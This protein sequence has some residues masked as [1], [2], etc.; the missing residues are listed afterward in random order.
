VVVES[1]VGVRHIETVVAGVEV[2]WK[3][4]LAMTKLN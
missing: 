2:S 4:K 3:P 1:T